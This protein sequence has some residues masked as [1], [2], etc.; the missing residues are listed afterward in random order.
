[1]PDKASR[2]LHCWILDL[3]GKV[4]L[5]ISLFVKG[6]NWLAMLFLGFMAG[7]IIGI[8]FDIVQRPQRLK[9][10]EIVKQRVKQMNE[11]IQR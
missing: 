4:R 6:T 1:L 9:K 3:T 7:T 2:S 8:F 11:Q 10:L 5:T